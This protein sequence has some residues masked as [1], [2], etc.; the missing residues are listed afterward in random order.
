MAVITAKALQ[1]SSAAQLFLPTGQL[2]LLMTC[3]Y[4]VGIGMCSC[5]IGR[6]GGFC[7]HQA[8]VLMHFDKTLSNAPPVNV[9]S[10]QVAAFLAN[11][12]ISH[13]AGFY[14]VDT[15]RNYFPRSRQN[16]DHS[17]S[18]RALSSLYLDC[19]L[20]KAPEFTERLMTTDNLDPVRDESA[21]VNNL[22]SCGS[23]F[24]CLVDKITSLKG[25]DDKSLKQNLDLSVRRLKKV[26]NLSELN[27]IF[28]T[29]GS[30]LFSGKNS[31]T[32]K[33]KVQPTALSRRRLGLPR[34][35]SCLPAGRPAKGIMNKRAKRS[36][37][38]A[39]NIKL[40]QPNAKGHGTGH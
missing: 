19:N 21:S 11:G 26:S 33:I 28:A 30:S 38:L 22:N 16:C 14:D 5:P 12:V 17:Y 9:E 39:E 8:V 36:R 13:V 29:F 10:R 25:E 32:K 27:S 37:S 4:C 2:R 15:D 23:F 31:Y 24:D 34:G 7:K 3:V 35:S 1:W 40:D 6:C 18:N 20:R